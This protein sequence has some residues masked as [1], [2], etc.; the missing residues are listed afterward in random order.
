MKSISIKDETS[1]GKI[2]RKISLQ[3]EAEYITVKELIATRIQVEVENYDNNLE[4]YA[5]GLVMPTNLEGR[6][7]EKQP[8]KIDI[9]KQIY[10]ALDAFKKNGFFIL[11]DDEQVEELNQKILVDESTLVSFIKLTPLVGG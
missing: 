11:V 6:L 8:P 7:N 1:S 10:T 4:S 5:S 9:E 2:L 3:F